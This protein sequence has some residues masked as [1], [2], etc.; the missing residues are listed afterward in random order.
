MNRNIISKLFILLAIIAAGMLS[1]TSVKAGDYSEKKIILRAG[2][3]E[4]K[5]SE[6]EFSQ[7]LKIE[8]VLYFSE[9]GEAEI[10]NINYCPTAKSFCDFFTSRRDHLKIGKEDLISADKNKIQSYL[11][12]LAR[13]VNKDPVDAKFQVADGKVSVFAVSE[14]G[15]ALDIEKRIG[16]IAENIL[17]EPAGFSAKEINLVYNEIEP[18]IKSDETDNLGITAL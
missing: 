11:A 4:E 2:R 10:E 16:I 17:R 13:R 9:S 5:L 14:N 3:Q 8:P 12:D 7:W 6:E 15:L 18:E 1:A